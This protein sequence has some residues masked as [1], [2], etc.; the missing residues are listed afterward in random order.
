[1]PVLE[2]PMAVLEYPMAGE[3]K[4]F[5]T[6][7]VLTFTVCCCMQFDMD[8]CSPVTFYYTKYAALYSSTH[9]TVRFE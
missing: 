3:Q 2:Y 5:F 4:N 7:P 6:V 1:M 9:S 8:D